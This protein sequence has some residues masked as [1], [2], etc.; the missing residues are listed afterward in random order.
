MYRQMD[1]VF[2]LCINKWMF[3]LLSADSA[4]FNCLGFKVFCFYEPIF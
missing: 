1:L 3:C 2:F 4:P